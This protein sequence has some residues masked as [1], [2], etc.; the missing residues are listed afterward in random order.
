[1]ALVERQELAGGTDMCS[2]LPYDTGV[3]HCAF[4]I[5]KNYFIVSV[6]MNIFNV[7]FLIN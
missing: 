6:H 7:V 2:L 3:C 4:D 1:M 5:F